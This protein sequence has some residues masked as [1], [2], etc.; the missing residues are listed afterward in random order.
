MTAEPADRCG[1][2]TLAEWLADH[3]ANCAECRK[4]EGGNE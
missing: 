3:R 1:R 4:T 2:R